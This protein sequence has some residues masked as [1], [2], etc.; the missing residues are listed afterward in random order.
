[1]ESDKRNRVTVKELIEYLK[2]FPA[3]LEVAETRY[4]DL[5][6]MDLENWRVM[7]IVDCYTTNG[8]YMRF[9]T[10]WQLNHP[11]PR[12]IILKREVKFVLHFSGN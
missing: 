7:K 2:Q 6:P 3:E 4:S 1:M 11:N 10:D 5:Q 12:E 8:Y 9:P